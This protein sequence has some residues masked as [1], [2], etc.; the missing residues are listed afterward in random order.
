MLRLIVKLAVCRLL[1]FVEHN[2][3]WVNQISVAIVAEATL[4]ALFDGEDSVFYKSLQRGAL[5]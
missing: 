4:D 2:A 3:L 1:F 5:R